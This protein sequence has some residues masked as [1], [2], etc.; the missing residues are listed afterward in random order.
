MKASVCI[1]T[2]FPLLQAYAVS[3]AIGCLLGAMSNV[4]FSPFTCISEERWLPQGHVVA[5]PFATLLL[6]HHC[7]A[8]YFARAECTSYKLISHRVR[9]VLTIPSR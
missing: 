3:R 9:T 6:H 8:L 1:G 5:E 2:V 4:S 7:S